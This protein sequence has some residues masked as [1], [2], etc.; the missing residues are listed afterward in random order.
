MSERPDS[1]A[2]DDDLVVKDIP[3]WGHRIGVA[4]AILL[5]LGGVRACTEHHSSTPP[6]S[7]SPPPTSQA[8]QPAV[9]AP[10]STG[11]SNQT[12]PG[13]S[14][15]AVNAGPADPCS[16]DPTPAPS[17]SFSL[18]APVKSDQSNPDA[19]VNWTQCVR[20][21]PRSDLAVDPP[22]SEGTIRT[23][24]RKPAHDDWTLLDASATQV[25]C[26]AVRW[27]STGS[28]PVPVQAAFLS[29]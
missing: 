3:K 29:K 25:Q 4:I 1:L 17:K 7:G 13:D 11:N 21:H 9:S 16:F 19:D 5:V 22:P 10:S 8:P 18:V 6:P 15:S 24:C 26:I 23:E 14:N 2:D 28:T 20:N 12:V 27:Q